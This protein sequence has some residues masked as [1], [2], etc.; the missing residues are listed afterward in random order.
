LHRPTVA[1]ILSFR[2]DSRKVAFVAE[3]LRRNELGPPISRREFSREKVIAESTFQHCLSG[4]TRVPHADSGELVDVRERL[5]TELGRS[6][7]PTSVCSVG[8]TADL[9]SAV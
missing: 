3:F 6:S 4:Q 5:P 8:K 2:Q 7:T 9:T 1:V